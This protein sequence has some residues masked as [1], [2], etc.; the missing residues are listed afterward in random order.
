MPDLSRLLHSERMNIKQHSCA[1]FVSVLLSVSPAV[2]YAGELPKPELLLAKVYKPQ[3]DIS[4]YLMSEKFDGVRA[5]WNG[6]HFI[7]RQGNIFH[8]PTWFSENFPKQPLDG[9]L[10]LA[11]NQFEKLLSAVSK[12]EPVDEEWRELS[13]RVFEL[14]EAEGVFA[15]RYKA[16]SRLLDD[17][18]NPYIK[19]VEQYSVDSH[20]A[21]M[22]RLDEVVNA[23]A[24][25][26]ML[27][28]ELAEYETGR[29]TALLKVKRYEDAEARVIQHLPGKG[30]YLGMMG[31]LLVE[32]PEGVRFKVGSGF[33]DAERA[34]PPKIGS[35]VTYKYYGKTRKGKPKFASFM[36]V[37]PTQ[38]E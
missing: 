31:A 2:L 38:L 7:S 20:E 24:E 10:W 1:F 28:D 21:L 16:L 13:Y 27:H 9:E 15:K 30:K 37:R 23:G 12:D 29:S 4:R 25:G 3:S 5:Y 19:L 14:P 34:N 22:R 11:R 6:E 35:M 36:R 32:T 8:S 17:I 33:S 26:L 18:D